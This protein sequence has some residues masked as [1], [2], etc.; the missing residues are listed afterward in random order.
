MND[1][2][3]LMSDELSYT[4]YSCDTISSNLVFYIDDFI[5]KNTDLC[6]VA[7]CWA[8][9]TAETI[10][11]FYAYNTFNEIISSL[12]SELFID[13]PILITIWKGEQVNH[14]LHMVKGKSHPKNALNSTIRGT[15][16]CDNHICNLIHTPDSTNEA[17]RELECIK[18]HMS[19]LIHYDA[20]KTVSMKPPLINHSG[21]TMLYTALSRITFCSNITTPTYSKRLLNS[22]SID[23]YD[24]MLNKLDVINIR[25]D[26][27]AKDL[28]S[29]YFSSDIDKV[30][31][32]LQRNIFPLTKWEKF[33]L[34]CG[35]ASASIWLSD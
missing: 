1:V 35:A 6:I 26:S 28:V 20:C 34:N 18:A 33:V 30:R 17:I 24:E 29:A 32:I 10:K 7:R 12:V 9:H 2:I 16:L 13:V 4:A 3:S 25:M 15:F 14:K 5:S 11:E 23:Y 31:F 27:F 8:T 21:I 22:N 19:T